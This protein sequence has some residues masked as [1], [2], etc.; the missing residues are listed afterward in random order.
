M[1]RLRHTSVTGFSCCGSLAACHALR[2]TPPFV[3][4]DMQFS[5]PAA[6]RPHPALL[7]TLAADTRRELRGSNSSQMALF[8]L[9]VVNIGH[10]VPSAVRNQA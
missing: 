6:G 10:D 4:P 1:F 3:E 8:M 7:K 9:A 2:P 5:L